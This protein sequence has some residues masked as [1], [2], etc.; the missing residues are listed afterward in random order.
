VVGRREVK[1]VKHPDR[2]S[3]EHENR[4]AALF[5]RWPNLDADEM[6]EL[7]QLWDERVGRSKRRN[8]AGEDLAA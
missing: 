6:R 3:L 4:M 8:R 5:R 1:V 7:R 2:A